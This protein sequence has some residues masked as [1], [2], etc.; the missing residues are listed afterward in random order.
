MWED[1]YIKSRAWEKDSLLVNT[2][3]G[4]KACFVCDETK[5]TSEFPD[6]E[7][8]T[9]HKLPVCIKCFKRKDGHGRS[10]IELFDGVNRVCKKCERE[11]TLDNFAYRK[12]GN[13]LSDTCRDCVGT[14][15]RQ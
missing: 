7:E 1:E 11:L 8:F 6:V 13:K 3:S 10:E 4:T 15:E 14:Y 12:N 2:D 5:Y 9:D